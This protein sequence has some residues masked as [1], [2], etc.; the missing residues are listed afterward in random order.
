MDLPR[1][2]GLIRDGWRNLFAQLGRPGVDR[3]IA[4]TMGPEPGGMY[5]DPRFW[6]D[7]CR[8]DSLA[9]RAVELGPEG[10]TRRGWDIA[11]KGDEADAVD[12]GDEDGEERK[13]TGAALGDYGR[14]LSIKQVG[15][16]GLVKAAK[17]GGSLV[18]FGADDFGFDDTLSKMSEALVE[19][20]I[21]SIRWIRVYERAR[22]QPGPIT[23]DPTS[24]NFGE[25]EHYLVTHGNG[26]PAFTAHWTRCHRFRGAP[27]SDDVRWSLQGW[28][29]S[30]LRGAWEAQRDYATVHRAGCGAILDFSQGVYKIKGLA[31]LIEAGKEADVIKRIRINEES[32]SAINAL[33]LDAEGEDFAFI[34]RSLASVPEIM[35]RFGVRLAAHY[36]LPITKLFGVSPGGFGTGEAEAISYEALCEAIQEDKL[37]PFL[38]KFYRLAMLAKDGPT[39]G[40]EKEIDIVFAPVRP[41]T[42]KEKAEFRKLVGE[43]V[44]ALVEAAIITPEEAATSLFGGERFSMEIVLDKEERER[45]KKEAEEGAGEEELS[46]LAALLEAT[47]AGGSPPAAG[48]GEEPEGGPPQQDELPPRL[49][50]ILRAL[51]FCRERN[52]DEA[53]ARGLLVDVCG[54]L[55]SQADA[56]VVSL[57]GPSDG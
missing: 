11:V 5:D 8:N 51:E 29:D 6:D 50:A 1:L 40:V 10:A 18:V 27:V 33:L 48:E 56:L 36:G 34:A 26:T 54:V 20:S 57:R 37:A 47:R 22:V 55:P 44:K 41:P 16:D 23:V 32:R 13:Q 9:R 24:P 30:E 39:G 35:D 28:E 12:E 52:V 42:E 4:T 17:H 2:G 25:P 3:S 45:R 38:R 15:R 21:K 19:T 14:A 46:Q 7:V 49:L 53:S 31:R 43:F